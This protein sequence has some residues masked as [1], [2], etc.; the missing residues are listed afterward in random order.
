MSRSAHGTYHGRGWIVDV[1]GDAESDAVLVASIHEAMHDRLQMTTVYGMLVDFL[2]GFARGR[3]DELAARRAAA[4]L[5][6]STRVHEEFATW[7]SVVP[8]GWGMERLTAEFPLYERHLARAAGRVSSLSGPYL[9]MH[10]VQAVARACMQPAGVSRMLHRGPVTQLS[11]SELRCVDRPDWRL[12]RLDEALATRGWGPLAS[13]ESPP[14]DLELFAEANDADWADL[15]R[16]AYEHCR[17][18]LED[19]G[20]PTLPYD[21]HLPAVQAQ[22]EHLGLDR[23]GVDPAS[24]T[25]A[26]MSVE[27]ETIVLQGPLRARL[28][29]QDLGPRTMLAGGDAS[30]HLFLAIR[31]RI[32][33]AAQYQLAEPLRASPHLA[34]LR[35]EDGDGV[36]ELMDVGD[37]EPRAL[38]EAGHLVI[39]ISMTSL[40][41]VE[42]RRRWDPILT[43]ERTTVLL[44]QRPSVNLRSW[45]SVPGRRL[46][47]SLFGVETLAGWV[48]VLAFQVLDGGHSSRVYLTPVS[49]LYSA[50]LLMS[51]AES[52]ELR[53][54]VQR[55]DT[56]ADDRLVRVSIAHILL[57]ERTFDCKAGD[58]W[59]A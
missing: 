38:V 10:A 18:L 54:R 2:A 52:D 58:N 11:P 47:Y 5:R 49:R 43:S 34:L 31:P 53:G 13:R 26:L 20:C 25:V 37:A 55:D 40:D 16:E 8:T 46:R 44:D 30:P 32:R 27:S 59:H 7:M 56:L 14:L 9:C 57:E 4:L 42:V 21:G 19:D 22:S 50:G 29:P 17:A 6:S 12:A 51:F 33:V 35:C 24:A 1:G 41:D 36:V 28:V 39:N 15:S 3:D 48:S 23:G 45:L